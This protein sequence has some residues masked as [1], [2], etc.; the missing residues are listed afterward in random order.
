MKLSFSIVA[1]VASFTFNDCLVEAALRGV[2]S[3]RNLIYV[4]QAYDATT[5]TSGFHMTGDGG[6]GGTTTGD[7][8]TTD[9]EVAPSG[10]HMDG[11]GTT[12]TGDMKTAT[13]EIHTTKIQTYETASG[14]QV[15]EIESFDEGGH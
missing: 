14:N 11:D 6:D 9:N 8:K 3:Q 10:F 5:M 12:T 13:E 2:T 15:I 7:M 1:A 4:N